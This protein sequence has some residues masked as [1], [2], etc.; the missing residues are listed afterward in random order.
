MLPIR[1]ERCRGVPSRWFEPFG[2]LDLF[3]D[4]D[5]AVH[6]VFGDGEGLRSRAD[7]WEDE[8][9]LY[10][11][12]E[13][14]GLKPEEVTL[15]YEDGILRIEG[16]SKTPERKGHYHL[17]ERRYGTF[18]RAFQLPNVIDP[19]STQ[20]AFKHGILT[21]TLAKRPET[22]ARKIEIKSE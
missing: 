12:L 7:V 9:N 22:K 5:H 13:L 14:P 6:R 19:E 17:S 8:E 2:R 4:F 3:D 11:E 21:V 16:E 20:A 15:N 10:V 1:V 18:V